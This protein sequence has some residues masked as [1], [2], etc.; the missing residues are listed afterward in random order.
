MLFWSRYGSGNLKSVTWQKSEN[1]NRTRNRNFLKVGNGTVKNSYGSTKLPRGLLKNQIMKAR[2][3]WGQGALLRSWWWRDASPRPPLWRGTPRSS[4]PASTA[5]WTGCTAC[6]NDPVNGLC[7]M[8]F[9]DFI[10]CRYI[11]S[12]LVFSNRLVNCCPHGRRNYTCVLL[13]LY[14]LSDLPPFTFPK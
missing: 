6:K 14:L 4:A 1:R 12:W 11:H 13:P 10:D 8:C 9:T 7:G 5:S 3:H 2:L